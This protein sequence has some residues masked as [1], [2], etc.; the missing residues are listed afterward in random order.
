[1]GPKIFVLGFL[2]DMQFHNI[3]Q[4][5]LDISE[6]PEIEKGVSNFLYWTHLNKD[7]QA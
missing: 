3:M 2:V 1:M 6:T 5:M 4:M 7:T